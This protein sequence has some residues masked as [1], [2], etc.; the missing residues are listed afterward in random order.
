MRTDILESLNVWK[1]EALYQAPSECQHA[2]LRLVWHS[3]AA[4][5]RI[6]QEGDSQINTV[7]YGT[8]TVNS[9]HNI[10]KI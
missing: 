3:L 6:P 10:Q 9:K 1:T 7:Q 2:D 4:L 5:I 8:H